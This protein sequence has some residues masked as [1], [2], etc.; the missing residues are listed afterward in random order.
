MQ[1]IST[2]LNKP[3][4]VW[5]DTFTRKV[6]LVVF[7]EIFS[8][9][10]K[11]IYKPFGMELS[12]NYTLSSFLGHG[13]LNIFVL[14]FQLFLLPKLF[15]GYFSEKNRTVGRQIMWI[16]VLFL[17]LTIVHASFSFF[18]GVYLV[19]PN[20]LIDSLFVN[21]SIGIFPIAI[22]VLLGY[23]KQ[24][25][26]KLKEK[27]IHTAKYLE[28]E[29]KNELIE[30][31]SE[32]GNEKIQ[33]LLNNLLYVKSADNYSE[34][35]YNEGGQVNRKILRTTLSSIEDNI[36]SE[37]L[38]KI[39]RSYIINLQKIDA[40]K[41]NSNKCNITL[42]NSDTSFPVSRSKRKELLEKLKKFPVQ[43]KI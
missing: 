20:S 6:L 25:E 3:F 16:L 12:G 21:L 23:V 17:V 24:L 1:K 27:E 18:D 26:D 7:I 11:Y 33:L 31:A 15:K 5:E 42:E 28:K 37:Y 39:H 2:W 34:V 41:G 43:Y 40:V 36:S 22:I 19:I 8:I 10:F 14:S 4:P 30:I 38:F 35:Y 9:G 32:T 13:I 29:L